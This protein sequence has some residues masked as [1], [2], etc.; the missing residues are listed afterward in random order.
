MFAANLGFFSN[1]DSAKSYRITFQHHS[2]LS[3]SKKYKD[4][5]A[6]ITIS[7]GCSGKHTGE[8]FR[9]TLD[10]AIKTFQKVTIMIDDSVQ[11]RTLAIDN[12]RLT[13]EELK[14]LAISNGDNWL[15][16]N[17]PYIDKYMLQD[18]KKVTLVRWKDWEETEALN[19][20]VR[21]MSALYYLTGEAHPIKIAIDDT[22]QAFLERVKKRTN[23]ENISEV[24]TEEEIL[25]MSRD[26]LIE[27]CAV[28]ANLWPTLETNFELYPSERTAA[29]TATYEN[30]IKDKHPNLLQALTI[31]F[32]LRNSENTIESSESK[33]PMLGI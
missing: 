6:Q 31:R 5:H 16:Q 14:E 23:W 15:A 19:N 32:K 27:E 12:P 1:N 21:E 11:W 10:K 7:V 17:K 3:S 24:H 18:E 29:M 30:L 9:D 2:T 8:H 13:D 4:S 26:Y 25:E 22:A 33:P 28:M 20:A